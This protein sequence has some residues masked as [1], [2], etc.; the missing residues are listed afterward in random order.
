VSGASASQLLR[1]VPLSFLDVEQ[2]E[3]A[4][5]R[6]WAER[7]LFVVHGLPQGEITM[8]RPGDAMGWTGFFGGCCVTLL[9]VMVTAL[10]LE[11]NNLLIAFFFG[12]WF[13][14]LLRT[15][16]ARRCGCQRIAC[17]ECLS[18]SVFTSCFWVWMCLYGRLCLW[19]GKTNSISF[20][21]FVL[22]KCLFFF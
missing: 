15:R 19:I 14:F 8:R 10:K 1:E 2:T 5:V 12:R 21:N 4:D 11:R 22:L 6:E 18:C 3:L 7:R 16:W 20:L 9:V 13:S 17:F